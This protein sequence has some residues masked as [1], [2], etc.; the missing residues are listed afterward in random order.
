MRCVSVGT[1]RD[2]G[3]E[4]RLGFEPRVR[5][6]SK[7][8]DN[9]KIST[10]LSEFGLKL[11]Y[12]DYKRYI[13]VLGRLDCACWRN[14]IRSGLV[15]LAGGD[16]GPFDQNFSSPCFSPVP[17]DDLLELDVGSASQPQWSSPAADN[18]LQLQERVEELQ[19]RV[20]TLEEQQKMLKVPN[21]NVIIDVSLL[22]Y[23][24]I[25]IAC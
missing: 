10:L 21:Y 2:G 18:A 13:A 5:G 20:T 22:C 17:P 3:E 24:S 19:V 25:G 8:V 4:M 16:L 23:Q 14:C 11:Q 7:R 12:A 15:A 9:Y 6:G 1:R